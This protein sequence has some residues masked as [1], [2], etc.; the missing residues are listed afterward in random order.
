MG[1]EPG[2]IRSFGYIEDPRVA[3]EIQFNGDLNPG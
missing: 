3:H 2:N 1:S